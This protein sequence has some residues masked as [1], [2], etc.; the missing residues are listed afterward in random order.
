MIRSGRSWRRQSDRARRAGVRLRIELME[1]RQLLSTFVV[2]NTSDGASP[3]PNS[4]RW[5]I[6]QVNDDTAEDTIDF[7]ITAGGFQS[8]TLSSPLPAITNSVV[9][10]GAT[11][12]GY[13][14]VP[15][16]QINGAGL[17]GSS[18]ALVISGGQ[19]TIRGLSL[20]GFSGSAIVLNTLGGDLIEGNAIGVDPSGNV[21]DANG[22]G[23]LVSGTSNNTIGGSLAG[24]GN[25][26]SGNTAS[27]ILIE[28]GGG[29]AANNEIAAN[30]IGTN[31]SGS[32]ALGNG[33]AGI[34][35]EG[36]S[37]TEIGLAEVGMGNVVSG[38]K[39]P[40]IEVAASA[41]VTVIQNNFIGI[42]ANG[43]TPIGNGGDGILLDNALST[44]IGGTGKNQGNL[45]G[46]NQ[47]NGIETQGGAGALIEANTIGTDLTGVLDLGNRGDGI[48]LGSSSNTVGGVSAGAANTIDDNGNGQVGSGVQLVGSVVGNSILSNSIFGNAGLG[49]NLGNGPTPS[50]APGTPGPN[51][52]QNYPTLSLAQSNGTA[53]MINGSLYSVPAT[54]FVLQFF[55]SPSQS[56]SGFGQGKT[57]VGSDSVTTDASGNVTFSVPLP[58]SVTPGEYVSATA[59]V[60]GGDTSE[61][62]QDVQ[63]K[64][65]FNLV[66]SASA[67][68]NPVAAGGQLTY[69][70]AITNSGSI[71]APAVTLTDAI[72]SGL[73]LV[74]TAVSQGYV[75]PNSQSV[76]V[77]AMIGTLAPGATATLTIVTQTTAASVGI[78]SD[79]ASGSSGGIDPVSAVVITNVE[80]AADLSVTLTA[81]PAPVLAG[82]DLTDTISIADA[83]PDGATGVTATLPL[84][85]GVA[86]VSAGPGAATVTSSNGQVFISVGSI[87]AGTEVTV[88]VLVQP[89]IVGSLAQT[90]YLSST[91]FDPVLSNNTATTTTEVDPAADLAVAITGSAGAADTADDFTYT[92][93]AT[94]N[95][96]GTDDG[97]QLSDTLPVGVS[98]VSLSSSLGVPTEAGGVV[99]LLVGSM[100]EGAT[101]TL[102]I[103][104]TPTVAPGSTMLD[105]ASVS[106]ALAD[107][108][109]GNNTASLTTAVFGVSDL[110]IT[111]APP[112]GLLYVGGNLVYTLTISNEGPDAEPDASLTCPIPSTVGLGPPGDGSMG[113]ASVS[114]GIMTDD[115]GPLA[116]GATETVTVVLVP[117]AAAAGPLMTTFAI[118][119]D[120][121]D[122]NLSDNSATTTV[123]V[124][125]AADLAVTIT[126]GVTA[127]AEEAD[128]TYTLSVANLG[129]SDATGVTVNSALPGNASVV[130]VTPSQ[131]TY[132]NAGGTLSVNVG[133]LEAGQVATVVVVVL[134]TAAGNLPLSASVSE[135]QYDPNIANNTASA[136]AMVAPSVDLSVVLQATPESVVVGKALTLTATVSN[137]GPSPATDVAVV[138]PMAGA[139]RFNSTAVTAGSSVLVGDQIIAQVGTVNPGSSVTLT[140]I[141]TPEIAG[142]VIQ[143]ASVT[144]AEDQLDPATA[145]TT[146]TVTVLESAGTLQF[147]AS[148]YS[149]ANTAGAAVLTVNRTVGWMGAVTVQYQT[150][151]VDAKPGIDF[152]PTSGTLTLAAGQATGTIAVPV[153]D[154]LWE[155]HNNLVN[156]E[157]SSP[158]G[159]AALGSITT[160]QLQIIDSDPDTTPPQVSQ[161]TWTG[162]SK[163]ITSLNL[164]FT[165]P[166]D[167]TFASNP[168]NFQ[169]SRDAAGQPS[170]AISSVTFNPATDSVTVVPSAPL[171]SGV[172][173]EIQ[174]SGT[175]ATAIRDL[176]GNLLEGGSTAGSNYVALFGQGTKLSYV[177]NTGNKVSLKL[178]GGGYM[179]D[180]LSAQSTGQTLTIIGEVPKRSAL[181][182]TV[183]KTK[184][185]TGSTNLGTIAGLGNFGNVRVTLKSPAFLVKQ[186]PFQQKGRG[187]L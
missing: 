94:N 72:P 47:A 91:S 179:K 30:H 51:D 109:P 76:V 53:T 106:G 115:L 161:L 154:N 93:T 130:S 160:T 98:V 102:T 136:Q 96:A 73:S 7:E 56:A 153:L 125:P 170:I 57:L 46:C 157:L 81:G 105:L 139:W 64:G 85:A 111:A 114:N 21:A 19:S 133:S 52:Y 121:I 60:P 100:D 101:A 67:N 187:S 9:I 124:L 44:T 165:A 140:I 116:A 31:A 118:E 167:A 90:V 95:G 87:A 43:T 144:A 22:Q 1:S 28:N 156:V 158:G 8:I 50:H 34:D 89:T 122:N 175:G 99:T 104:I 119:G 134:P 185:S 42:A 36:A 184:R 39:G 117:Q 149:V 27:G 45:I 58:A 54:T 49:I 164:S 37:G 131:G 97:V 15:L 142:T 147:S 66:L 68:P 24:A 35:I 33:A 88:T 38:N 55:A 13:S 6:T 168:A 14:G 29:Q 120:N 65:V 5:A 11:E 128:W 62:A 59:S 172:F 69:S 151:A 143:Q 146:T 150:V 148:L 183:R 17:G 182:G 152:L 48:E 26:I 77:T 113:Q 82:G 159:G 145:T 16:I 71:A 112:S 162:T 79:T 86:F 138:L 181:S 78:V 61:F 92:V 176:A 171:A 155:N 180:V 169:L 141:V 75:L 132:A 127:L 123:T 126:P 32:A 84:P 137:A 2:S 41:I 18:N 4:L 107:P 23:I 70:L 166:L 83:G 186:Y 163:A 103:V 174:A 12:Q 110:G 3:A 20:V 74:S 177:D 108:V 25:V 178:A 10:D 40:G 173:Y 129:L 63:T 135:D 80:P